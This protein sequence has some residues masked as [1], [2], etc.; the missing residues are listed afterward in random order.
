[1]LHEKLLRSI[2]SCSYLL[3]ALIV[4]AETVWGVRGFGGRL[5]TWELITWALVPLVILQLVQS[6]RLTR[7]WPLADY[8]PQ[9]QQ[10][11]SAVLVLLLWLWLLTSAL[12]S[13]G[14]AHPLPFLPICNPLELSQLIV[15]FGITRWVIRHQEYVCSKI[16]VQTFV[17]LGGSTAFLWLNAALARSVH[18][19]GAVPFD[20]DSMLDSRLYQA[21]LSVLW[22]VLSLVLMVT[23]HRL[24]HRILWLIGAGLVGIT[25]GKLFLIDLA[26]SGTVERIVSFLAVGTLLMIIGYFAPLPPAHFQQEGKS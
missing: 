6:V 2:H 1:L 18:Q 12:L 15:F 10:Q 24:K 13:S 17:I 14:N 3:L 11:G 19:F 16:P 20:V 7:Y 9:Y 25:V 22:G 8:A 26:N 23:A 5:D 21:A 4:T